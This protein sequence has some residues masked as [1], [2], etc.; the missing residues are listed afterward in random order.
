VSEQLVHAAAR[1]WLD[2]GVAAIVVRVVAVQG[3]APREAGARMVVTATEAAGTIGGGHLELQALHAA[4]DMLR[5]GDTSAREAR[6]ALGPALGQCCGGAVALRWERLSRAVLADWPP[7]VP[8]LHLQLY[9][10]GHVGRAI[11]ALCA[12][13]DE[14]SVEWIDEREDAFP[15]ALAP[16]APWPAH[17]HRVGVD[18]VDGEVRHAPPG[19]C[20][21]VLTHSHDLDLRI[22]EAV[23]RRGDFAFAGLIGSQSKR[24]RFAHR[25]QARGIGAEAVARLACP[26]GVPGIAG[27]APGVIAVSAVAQLLQV[28]R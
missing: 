13:L 6:F 21:L 5:A 28:R 20:Y 23:L 14:F 22:V 10:A 12:S 9:G 27:K 18:A 19:A 25:L 3:S 26:I 4:R 11:A 7:I 2:A 15:V 17:I 24:A 16:G 1:R 8:R